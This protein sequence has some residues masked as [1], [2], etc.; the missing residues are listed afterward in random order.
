MHKAIY[1]NKVEY[2]CALTLLKPRLLYISLIQAKG[3]LSFRGTSS[4]SYSYLSIILVPCLA[5]YSDIGHLS[6][7]CSTVLGSFQRSLCSVGSFQRALLSFS[8]SIYRICTIFPLYLSK[9]NS[10]TIYLGV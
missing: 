3:H 1:N 7:L 10:V 6:V 5:V 2:K 8:Y 9:L 4:D